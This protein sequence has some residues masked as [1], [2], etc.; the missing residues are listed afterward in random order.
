MS[1]SQPT[2]EN[3]QVVN[4]FNLFVDSERCVTQGDQQSRGDDVHIQFECN[5]IEA[6][7][8]EI[9]KLSVTDFSM[10]NNLSMIDF[11]N[12]RALFKGDSTYNSVT[13]SPIRPPISENVDLLDRQNYDNIYQIAES[14]AI[15]F[16]TQLDRL[17]DTTTKSFVPGEII[18][19]DYDIV[20]VPSSTT[21]GGAAG[22]PSYAAK[23]VGREPMGY[24]ATFLKMVF[25]CKLLGGGTV[26]LPT[27]ANSAHT[28]TR[29]LL[30][31]TP[32][33]GD[34]YSIL[35][36]LRCDNPT[37]N[38]TFNSL[39]IVFTSNSSTSVEVVGYF[40]MQRYAEPHI[41][42]RSNTGQN[43]LEMSVLQANVLATGNVLVADVVTSDIL[44]K[45]PRYIGASIPETIMYNSSTGMDYFIN[46]QQRKLTSLQLFLTD[47]KGR[48]LGRFTA[49]V[50]TGTA[51]GRET[52]P[53]TNPPTYAS[54]LQSTLGNLFFTATIR[55]DVIK[56]SN[57]T[58]LESK[59][60]PPPA[61]GSKAGGIIPMT[62]FPNR[63]LR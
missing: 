49:D 15:N 61:N 40:P 10:P 60:F 7:D 51:A 29:C 2:F 28:I 8:G 23:K 39:Q 6:G 16:K 56:A 4:S 44:G 59:V 21:A 42:L 12:S 24:G 53:E 32:T 47:S 52:F 34:I 58:K 41:Y 37:N 57:P 20:Y 43:G 54:P 25:Q 50:T 9:I 38:N 30:Q 3:Q 22:G 36:G 27:G 5:S 33:S 35:G 17:V 19:P 55:V 13:A 63:S 45:F 1:S 14:F 26:D 11:N 48:R 46:L 18:Y 62:G 31:F